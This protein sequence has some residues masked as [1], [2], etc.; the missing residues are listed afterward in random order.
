[1]I[2]VIDNYDSFTY[3]VVQYVGALGAEPV[4]RK[5]DALSVDDVR[6]LQPRGIIISS[7]AGRPERAGRCIELI[8]A[9]AG[10]VP[11]FG[12]GL[13]HQCI[14]VAFGAALAQG[15][16][17]VHGKVATIEHDGTGLFAGLHLP[18]VATRYD[19]AVVCDVNLPTALHV[20]ARTDGGEIAALRHS[21]LAVESV[22]FHPDSILTVNGQHIVQ[23]F[24]AMTDTVRAA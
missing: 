15:K 23:N 17:P 3:N 9:L 1:M 19:S 4:V 18:F 20:T 24:L 7:G 12:I 10:T 6:Q 5:N 14:A 21:T 22:Q 8:R 11:M 16:E 13:G 2:L